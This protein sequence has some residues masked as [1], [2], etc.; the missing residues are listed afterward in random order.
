MNREQDEQSKGS[1]HGEHGAHG[2]SS[3]RDVALDRRAVT[4]ALNRLAFAAELLDDDTVDAKA[5]SSLAWTLRSA[6]GEL[7]LPQV[8]AMDGVSVP[9]FAVIDD[10]NAG[11]E[12][13]LVREIE[14][15]IP[16]G[17]LE[18][19]KLK[20]LG[21]RKIRAL[22]QEL[23]IT[24]VGEL[25]YAC[26]EN[27][28]VDLKGFGDKTQASVLEQIEQLR[29]QAG[30]VR[31]DQAL[32][33]G[34]ALTSLLEQGGAR[35]VLA[36]EAR[37]RTEVVRELCIVTT[38]SVEAANAAV[39]AVTQK[40]GGSLGVQVGVQVRVRAGTRPEMFGAALVEETGSEA[41]VR[42]LEARAA[43]RGLVL[44]AIAAEAAGERTAEELEEA[45]YD[46]LGLV[47]LEPERREDGVP[48][49]E[50]GRAR[51]RL[52]SSEDIRGALH[53]H[54]TASDGTASMREMRDAAARAGLLYLAITD[55]SQ[56]AVYAKGLLASS[57]EAQRAE[58]AALN[59]EAGG[60]GGAGGARCV[61]LAGVES[62]ILKDGALDYPGDVLGRLDVVVASVHSR[63]GQRGPDLTARMIAAATNPFT[64]I[65]GHPTGRLLLGRAPAEYDVSAMLEACAAAGCAVELN[66]NPARLD[67][68]ERHLAEARERKIPVSIAADAHSTAALLHLEYGVAIARRAGLGPEDVL[69]TRP[70][71][72][73][74]AFFAARRARAREAA[75]GAKERAAAG[76]EA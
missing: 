35:A 4:D 20:G 58:A 25:E 26:Q 12:P 33:L 61:L 72:E 7:K 64:D 47:W 21:P 48:L 9:V 27:R 29:A 40:A 38:A 75:R 22:W 44:T 11:R 30:L 43:A 76:R 71:E 54:T 51:R 37:R 41:H 8:A 28:L 15:R 73:V 69:N 70:L 13:P 18:V 62:D 67:L 10:A 16:R 52:V 66:A 31:L 56:S 19:K 55:H 6:P 42:A 63:F 14:A 39:A 74:L 32:A 24:S 5:V 49:V 46:A 17:L 23:D 59:A 65:V 57:L 68:H 36:G 34:A 3:E 2:E 53:N 45:V 50:K 1:E 60:A